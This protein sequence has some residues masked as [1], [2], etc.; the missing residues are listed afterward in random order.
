M[1][2]SVNVIGHITLLFNDLI[3]IYSTLYIFL[4]FSEMEPSYNPN[5]KVN[6]ISYLDRIIFS[7]F[8]RTTKLN[9]LA[10]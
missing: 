3:F 1:E 7:R 8:S 5:K 9:I 6:K 2:Y 10:A 4:G